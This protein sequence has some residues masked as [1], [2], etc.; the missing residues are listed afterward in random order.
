MK[1]LSREQGWEGRHT[2]CT[3]KTRVTHG[4][5]GPLTNITPKLPLS[6]PGSPW[7]GGTRF[8]CGCLDSIPIAQAEKTDRHISKAP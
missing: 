5:Q 6:E 7:G 1:G 3:G 2:A 4:R 8:T